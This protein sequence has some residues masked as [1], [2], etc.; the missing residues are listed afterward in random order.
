MQTE[1]INPRPMPSQMDRQW[2]H[3]DGT[4]RNSPD[5]V[6]YQFNIIDRDTRYNLS[7]GTLIVIR[8]KSK[9]LQSSV[10]DVMFAHLM[11]NYQLIKV[12][13]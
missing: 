3:M 6:K 4:N 2:I 12:R 13:K 1:V 9:R 11:N 7:P 10:D 5:I 8:Q